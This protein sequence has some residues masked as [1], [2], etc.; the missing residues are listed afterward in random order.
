MK[1]PSRRNFLKLGST[2]LAAIPIVAASGNALAARNAAMRTSLK[3]QEQPGPD[4]KECSGCLQFV[5]GK[6]PMSPGGC[7]LYPGDTEISPKGYC[8]AWVKKA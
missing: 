7:K 6:T 1:N 2:L 8:I 5:P 3:Y 4:N